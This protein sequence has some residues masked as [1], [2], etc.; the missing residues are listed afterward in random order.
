MTD[1]V[2]AHNETYTP[3]TDEVRGAYGEFQEE[4]IG[5]GRG[6]EAFDRWLSSL[7][8]TARADGLNEAR[9]LANNAICND[10]GDW[11]NGWDDASRFIVSE[12]ERIAAV[13][14][15]TTEEKK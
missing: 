3:D 12:L 10:P 2:P 11:N 6:L 14:P 9:Q 4:W 13:V 15:L 1:S 8:A 7:L 5:Y